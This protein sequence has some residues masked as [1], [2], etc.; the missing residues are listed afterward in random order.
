MIL[1]F[2]G[3]PGS[4]KT[5]LSTALRDRGLVDR[6]VDGEDLRRILPNPG[7]DEAG[8]R[9]NIDRA[10]AISAFINRS[11]FGHYRVAVALVSPYRDQREAFKAAQEVLEIHLHYDPDLAVRG[12]EGYWV[13]DYEPPIMD[14]LDLDTGRLTVE[15]SV[16]AIHREISGRVP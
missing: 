11:G 3:Q 4:G 6:L 1:W 14:Y 5:T 10:Q 7:Y 9:Q 16:R 2:T 8:R 15:D 12:K 13:V